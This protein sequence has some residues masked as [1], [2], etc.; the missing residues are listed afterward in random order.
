MGEHGSAEASMKILEKIR[1]LK[2]ELEQ[3]LN[4]SGHLET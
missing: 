1:R 3:E 2:R 4:W